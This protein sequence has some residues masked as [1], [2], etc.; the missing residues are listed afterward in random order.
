MEHIEK[1]AFVI[2]C[3]IKYDYP[4]LI[5]SDADNLREIFKKENIV[6][7]VSW[8]LKKLDNNYEAIIN[9]A[10]P[11]K[12][13][14]ILESLGFCT[15]YNKDRF[16][17][18]EVDGEENISIVY[19]MFRFLRE[20]DDEFSETEFESNITTLDPYLTLDINLFL[21]IGS[22]NILSLEDKQKKIVEY[23]EEIQKLKRAQSDYKNG[24]PNLDILRFQS[25]LKE[26]MNVFELKHDFFTQNVN[27]V[28]LQQNLKPLPETVRFQPNFSEVVEECANELKSVLQVSYSTIK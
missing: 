19:N 1:F 12:L 18:G 27:N 15:K 25:P 4:Q 14:D 7:L 20:V 28:L 3:L 21:H 6:F 8:F 26:A 5:T 11:K 16:L 10:T 17:V 9:T 22:K 13:G 23:R 2:D 24:R